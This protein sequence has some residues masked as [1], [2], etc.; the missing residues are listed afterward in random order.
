LSP[1]CGKKKTE[2]PSATTQRHKPDAADETC[3][4]GCGSADA[5]YANGYGHL[6]ASEGADQVKAAPCFRK[7]C[8]L[9]HAD[10]CRGL[11]GMFDFGQGL[12]RNPRRASE[13]WARAVKLHRTGCDGGGMRDCFE[14]GILMFRGQGIAQDQPEAARLYRQACDGGNANGCVELKLICTGTAYPACF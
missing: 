8:E 4:P 3:T 2:D 6:Y 5:C 14:L 13:F 7:A 11:A 9:G 12:D 10:A 1:A